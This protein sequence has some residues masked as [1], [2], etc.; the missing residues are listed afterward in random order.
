MNNYDDEFKIHIEKMKTLLSKSKSKM[1]KTKLKKYIEKS[2]EL[3]E[4]TD[5]SNKI[6]KYHDKYRSTK[7]H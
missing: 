2:I 6:Y 7:L 5:K 1:M 3:K 4:N